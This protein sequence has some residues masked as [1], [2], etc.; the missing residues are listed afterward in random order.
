MRSFSRSRRP[1]PRHTAADGAPGH[2]RDTPA[3]HHSPCAT[4]ARRRGAHHRFCAARRDD[5]CGARPVRGHL[6]RC[7]LPGPGPAQRHRP[8][9]ARAARPFDH[10]VREAFNAHQRRTVD[11]ESLLGPD[12]VGAAVDRF[13][14]LGVEVL[15]RPSPWRLGPGQRALQAE[16]FDRTAWGGVRADTGPGGRGRCLCAAP[17]GR[18]VRR[19][20]PRHG[21]PPGPVRSA[22][23]TRPRSRVCAPRRTL[24]AR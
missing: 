14:R 3:R 2:H 4:R 24:V 18:G 11:G 9:G 1:T 19:C 17:P 10:R 15:V 21:A 6:R 20:A 8:G 23:M 12:A 5:G 16:W 13:E 7:G 22:A